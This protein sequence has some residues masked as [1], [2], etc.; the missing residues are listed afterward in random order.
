MNLP[1][2]IPRREPKKAKQPIRVAEVIDS[3]R[4]TPNMQRIVLSGEELVGFPPNRDGANFKIIIPKPNQ[5]RESFSA[6]VKDSKSFRIVRTY[7][8]STYDKTKNRLVVDFALHEGSGP[9]GDWAKKATIG[10]ILGV[11]NGGAKKVT[12][13]WGTRHLIAA[14]MTALPAIEAIFREL[15]INAKGDAFLEVS[16]PKDEREMGAPVGININWL[17]QNDPHVQSTAQVDRIRKLHPDPTTQVTAAGE[18]SVIAALKNYFFTERGFDPNKHYLSP[19]W[20]IGLVEDEHQA[21][22]RSEK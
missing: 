18:H 17:V 5:T 1:K 3:I 6:T 20:K 7:T 16:D 2:S 14:D 11:T 10:S 13:F 4:L 15:P 22:K 8:I 12:E 9:A 21:L 19:Y